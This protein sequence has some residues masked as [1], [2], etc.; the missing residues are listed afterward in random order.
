MLG[1]Y[2]KMKL[3][4]NLSSQIKVSALTMFMDEYSSAYDKKYMFC[5][6]IKIKNESS[7]TVQLLNRHWIILDSNSKKEE[8]KGAGVIGMQPKLE[9]G[10]EHEYI[11]FCNLETNFGSMEGSFEFQDAHGEHFLVEIPRFFIAET[12]NQLDKPSFRRGHMVRHKKEGFRALIT[13]YDMYFINDEELYNKSANRPAKDKPWFYLLIDE[14]NS[15]S[16]VAQENLELDEDQETIE[17]P[18]V[19]FFFD[20]FSDQDGHY[21]R[22]NK[23]WEQLKRG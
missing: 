4:T 14:T 16:Y 13:D 22:N 19:D 21:I 6:K 20:G 5:Y 15:I 12:L 17:H 23:T 7:E 18:L 11:S 3:E 8:V 10:G 2:L 9:P 1:W